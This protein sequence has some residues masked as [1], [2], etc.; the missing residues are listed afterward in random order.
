MVVTLISLVNTII[1]LI[2]LVRLDLE[3]FIIRGPALYTSPYTLCTYDY[4]RA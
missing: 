3:Q 2:S 4:V 1:T